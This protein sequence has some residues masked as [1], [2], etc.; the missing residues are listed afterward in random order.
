[1]LCKHV[2]C[3]I[4]FLFTRDKYLD[5]NINTGYPALDPT[6]NKSLSG[7]GWEIMYFCCFYCFYVFLEA[8]YLIYIYIYIYICFYMCFFDCKCKSFNRLRENIKTT[9]HPPAHHSTANTYLSGSGWMICIF[10]FVFL[11]GFCFFGFY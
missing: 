3:I 11:E 9:G 8:L 4:V 7:S 2:T 1:M 5:R 6:A 10:F